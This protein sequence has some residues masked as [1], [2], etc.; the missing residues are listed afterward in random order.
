MG[1][2]RINALED[3]YNALTKIKN[4]KDNKVHHKGDYDKIKKDEKTVRET[5]DEKLEK[6][7]TIKQK[8]KLPLKKFHLT[9][10]IDRTIT[11]IDK[12]TGQLKQTYKEDDHIRPFQKGQDTLHDSRIIEAR[13]LEEAKKLYREI[14]ERE[15]YYEEYSNSAHVNLDDIQFIDDPIEEDNIKVSDPKN[16]PLRQFTH[17]DYDFTTEEKK[18]LSTENTC[19][20][21]N[22][23]GVYGKE[24]K[25]N[26]DKLIKLNKKFHGVEDEVED[27]EPEF[28]ESDFGDMIINPKY[29]NNNEL[30][31]VEA[32]LK[33]Y[34]EEYNK[35]NM[36]IILMR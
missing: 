3:A 15:H 16:I 25:L 36:N 2:A 14:L 12:R 35:L 7:M 9:A 28:I 10:I 1:S 27:N 11:Y 17:L 22:L 6:L 29:N 20:I 21:D 26:K 32:K 8:T 4:S 24:L 33:K 13:S 19:V 23:I 5:K 18:Y 30:K 31:N 34:E